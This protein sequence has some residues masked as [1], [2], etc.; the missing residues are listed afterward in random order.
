[1]SS[2]IIPKLSKQQRDVFHNYIVRVMPKHRDKIMFALQELGVDTKIHYP[3]PLHLQECSKN[4]GYK[5]G[6]IPKVEK[7]SKSMISLPIFPFLQEKEIEYI[8]EKFNLV[9]KNTTK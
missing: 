1:M 3:I 5:N 7:L 8:I 4:L 6:D 2:S 9:I